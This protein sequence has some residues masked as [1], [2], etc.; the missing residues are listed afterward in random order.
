MSS[1]ILLVEDDDDIRTDLAA[2]LEEYGYSV[3]A[4][5]DGFEALRLLRGGG[6]PRLILLD[7]MMPEMNGWQLRLELLKDRQLASIPV[8]VM[9]GAGSLPMEAA[10]LG[11]TGF[12]SKPF[13][14]R[15]LLE[16]VEQCCAA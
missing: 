10:S 7:L 8:L 6:R 5:R 1:Q 2:M 9:S 15:R 11:A 14:L 12:V 16:L 4:V 13:D 3:T